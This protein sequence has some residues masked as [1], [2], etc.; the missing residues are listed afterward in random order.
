MQGKSNLLQLH[1]GIE[2]E[3]LRI[4]SDGALSQEPHPKTLGSS[5]AHPKITTDFC[6]AQLELITGV[7]QSAESCLDEL[8]D[9]HAFIHSELDDEL[10]WPASMP[11]G[12]GIDEEI[13]IARYGK[14]NAGRFKE[15]YRIGLGNRYGRVMQTISG[16]HYNVSIPNELWDAIA[17]HE[18]VD[19]DQTFRNTGYLRLVRNFRK[20]SWLLIYLFGASPAVC[21]TFLTNREHNLDILDPTTHHLPH[22]TSLRM[23]PLGYQSEAQSRHRVLYDDLTG[24]VQSMVP[25]LNESYPT[26]EAIGVREGDNYHQLNDSLLQIEAEF[27]GTIRLK[28]KTL[29]GERPLVG[30]Q[31][32]GVEYVEVRCMDIDPFESIGISLATTQFIDVFLL[33]SLLAPNS[34]ESERQSNCN[35]KNQL[36]VVHKGR[37]SGLALET[38]ESVSNMRDW[39][40]ELLAECAQIATMMDDAQGGRAF[41]SQVH[42][43]ID[44]VADTSLT[45]SA[46]MLRLMSD[47]N[48]PF[49][50]L[51][52]ELAFQ[53]QEFMIA[54]GLSQARRQEFK[55]LADQSHVDQA[56]IESQE[57]E[58]FEDYRTKL[59]SL[60]E[61]Q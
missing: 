46:R 58:S 60:N 59:L 16:I 28:R 3:T 1:R 22:A 17:A 34:S 54:R 35:L 47:R 53:Q 42:N 40:N 5:L 33:H 44:K 55:H 30:L 49:A 41:Q 20:H 23:G 8:A 32:R 31:N 19:N 57:S 56:A 38:P 14:S 51:G 27:Y 9:I 10:L 4:T 52:L 37:D 48:Q 12:I 21:R 29:P 26:Y 11:C 50:S 15:I 39:A 6:E 24:F 7:H 18:K 45:P 2:R 61:V 25:M 13:P 36:N 43:Q